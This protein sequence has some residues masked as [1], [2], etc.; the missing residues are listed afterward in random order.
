[1]RR[2]TWNVAAAALLAGLGV[3]RADPMPVV[4]FESGPVPVEVTLGSGTLS[5]GNAL[6]LFT[7]PV[8]RAPNSSVIITNFLWKSVN[9]NTAQMLGRLWSAKPINTT[10]NNGAAFV[11]SDVDDAALIGGGPFTFTPAAPAAT[12]GDSATY[13]SLTGL[14]WDFKN[15]DGATTV[16]GGLTN[17]GILPTTNV[18]LCVIATASDTLDV[19]HA[20]RVTLSGPQ[21]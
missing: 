20:V 12:T 9:G 14:T 19:S 5:A 7:I 1:M 4:G 21:N 18:Y 16:S 8:T 17:N 6:G 2:F 11:G 3:A 15:Q 13:A 10:C